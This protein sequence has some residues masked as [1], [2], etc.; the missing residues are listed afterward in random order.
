MSPENRTTRSANRGGMIRVWMFATI[1]RTMPRVRTGGRSEIEL[2][3]LPQGERSLQEAVGV[4]A[5]G[6][7]IRVRRNLVLRNGKHVVRTRVACWCG[8][9]RM[10]GVQATT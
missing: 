8:R 4:G 3:P 1:A 9:G 2:G 6:R 10:E 5:G 7:N